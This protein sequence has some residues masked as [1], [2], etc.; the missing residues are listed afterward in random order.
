MKFGVAFCEASGERKIRVDGNDS[1]LQGVATEN[2]QALAQ[3][4]YDLALAVDEL[5]NSRKQRGRR[6][7]ANIHGKTS[8][9]PEARLTP[10][11]PPKPAIKPVPPPVDQTDILPDVLPIFMLSKGGQK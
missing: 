7:A 8:T 5:L 4:K 11:V 9:H 2:A 10:G 3:A 6:R 1:E